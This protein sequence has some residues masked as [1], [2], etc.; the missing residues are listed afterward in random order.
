MNSIAQAFLL[1]AADK[2]LDSV[3]SAAEDL[4]DIKNILQSQQFENYCKKQQID[5]QKLLQEIQHRPEIED[6]NHFYEYRDLSK[7]TMA[8]M[9]ILGQ[10]IAQNPIKTELHVEYRQLR[11][12][13]LN[14]GL[15]AAAFMPRSLNGSIIGTPKMIKYAFGK[16][17]KEIDER[18]ELAQNDPKVALKYLL[19]KIMHIVDNKELRDLEIKKAINSKTTTKEITTKTAKEMCEENEDYKYAVAALEQL[20]YQCGEAAKMVVEV[21]QNLPDPN[22]E[23]IVA[24]ILKNHRL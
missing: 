8:D 6:T 5:H 20:G 11:E 24:Y 21:A 4:S 18:T 13:A 22:V 3:F 16:L 23:S 12:Q 2:T 10:T 1:T 14:V 7:V 17:K 19:K 15:N 9:R